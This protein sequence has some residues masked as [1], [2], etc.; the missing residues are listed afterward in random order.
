V[1]YKHHDYV[2]GYELW[3]RFPEVVIESTSLWVNPKQI[4]IGE[5]SYVGHCVEIHG[6]PFNK[7]SVRIG[8]RCFIYASTQLLGH[9]GIE[10]YDD[11]G[12]GAG[13]IVG[14][15]Q[16][17]VDGHPKIMA[18]PIEFK[19]VRIEKNA[20]IGSG[21]RICPGVTIGEGA[22]IGMG[23]VVTTNV[24]KYEVWA[25]NPARPIRERKIHEVS[26]FSAAV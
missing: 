6:Y 8:K 24:P 12:I 11:V 14:T 18:N 22:Q 25:G 15:S 2:M 16:H 1:I 3:T 23:A 5:G 7:I 20:D 9:G 10:I 17:V 19:P 4:D 21:A 26:V 13:V